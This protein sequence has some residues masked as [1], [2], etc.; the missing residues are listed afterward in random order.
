[1]AQGRTQAEEVKS[2]G[3]ARSADF[4]AISKTVASDGVKEFVIGDHHRNTTMALEDINEEDGAGDG[5]EDIEDS[6]C[7]VAPPMFMELMK[8]GCAAELQQGATTSPS[9][10]TAIVHTGKSLD[11]SYCGKK[12]K[13]GKKRK[14]LSSIAQGGS[15]SSPTSLKAWTVE[16]EMHGFLPDPHMAMAGSH[17]EC[18]HPECSPIGRS[19]TAQRQVDEAQRRLRCDYQQEKRAVLELLDELPSRAEGRDVDMQLR[20]LVMKAAAM[21]MKL[22]AFE[23]VKQGDSVLSAQHEAEELTDIHNDMTARRGCSAFHFG[24]IL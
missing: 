23:Q 11:S 4:A 7:Q 6:R 12:S 24:C 2:L 16:A 9:V 1:M 5:A 10:H 3:Q 22:S 20:I 21:K 19:V 18:S 13:K 15:A 8:G 14:L 17:P